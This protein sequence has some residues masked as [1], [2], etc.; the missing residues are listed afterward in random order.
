MRR[1]VAVDHFK[2]GQLPA[3]VVHI[4]HARL[5]DHM[6]ETIER[7]LKNIVLW[8]VS[9]PEQRQPTGFD[10]IAEPRRGNPDLARLPMR[11]LET[12]SKNTRHSFFS[13][14]RVAIRYLRVELTASGGLLP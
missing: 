12:W 7:D 11:P 13:S 8:I 3:R 14:W 10:L 5:S 1:L 6:V 2:A 9:N 4:D